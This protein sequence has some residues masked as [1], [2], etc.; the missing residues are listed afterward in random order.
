MTKPLEKIRSLFTAAGTPNPPL[1]LEQYIFH[2]QSCLD[3]D[4]MQGCAVVSGDGLL[5][6]PE[7]IDLLLLRGES[8]LALGKPADAE[9]PLRL[10]VQIAPDNP[11]ALRT[12]ALCLQEFT[13]QDAEAYE[14]AINYYLM[15]LDIEPGDV[16]ALNNLGALYRELGMYEPAA[17][18]FFEAL[19]INP[20]DPVLHSNYGATRMQMNLYD[21]D[22]EEHLKYAWSHGDNLYQAG[23]HL[24]LLYLHKGEREKAIGCAEFVSSIAEYRG[25]KAVCNDLNRRLPELDERFQ[26]RQEQ[27]RGFFSD[28]LM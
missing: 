27:A 21:R 8:L 14:E 7:D 11:Q 19:G 4:D 17:Q 23:Y 26:F 1:S 28:Y 9:E 12:L 22:T 13:K 24:V 15:S 16:L 25:D 3:H 5:R 2:A 18:C 10:A 6:Y 20:H